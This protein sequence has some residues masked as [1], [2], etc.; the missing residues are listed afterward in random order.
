M[1]EMPINTGLNE[2]EPEEKRPVA[3]RKRQIPA[4]A[5]CRKCSV[6]LNAYNADPRFRETRD[7]ICR[8][9]KKEQ[10]QK[11]S[12]YKKYGVKPEH[13]E[14]FL[15]FQEGRCA[16]CRTIFT[17]HMNKV[18]IDHCHETGYVR[19]LLC[20][21]CN[22]GLGSFRDNR[23]FLANAIRYLQHNHSPAQFPPKRLI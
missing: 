6:E 5:I 3:R 16:I 11:S 22:T 13:F 21:G 8:A 20:N 10:T 2:R 18:N 7:L 19:G 9:C 17:T 15:N 23:H 14:F 1:L 4:K 12:R